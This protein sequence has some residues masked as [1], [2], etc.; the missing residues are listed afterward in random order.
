MAN[1]SISVYRLEIKL[2]L[3]WKIT[4][5]EETTTAHFIY[6]FRIYSYH[7]IFFVPF[8]QSNLIF[9]LFIRLS[10]SKIIH[11]LKLWD[12]TFSIINKF[13]LIVSFFL[14]RDKNNEDDD[15]SWNN[16]MSR[17]SSWS[18]SKINHYLKLY[19]ETFSIINKLFV[20][21]RPF[22]F[23]SIAIKNVNTSWNNSM[24]RESTSFQNLRP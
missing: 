9:S 23:F 2:N 12:E 11:N 17:K 4:K 3:I 24:K 22:F 19:G 10:L 8:I 14:Y 13:V 15:R 7:P 21:E 20:F 5:E 16:S 18:L 6:H 1:V